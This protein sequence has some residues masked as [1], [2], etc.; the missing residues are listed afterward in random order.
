MSGRE[1][2]LRGIEHD[3]QVMI[4]ITYKGLRLDISHRA[5]LLIEDLIIVELKSVERLE[6][7]HDSQLLTYLRL[8]NRF[9]G[10]LFNFNTSSLK[11][12]LRRLLNG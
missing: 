2:R 1:L 11:N 3:R 10:L 7:I 9:L 4:P 12:G 5:D 6:P 8:S